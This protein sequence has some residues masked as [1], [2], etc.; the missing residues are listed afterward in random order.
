MLP[1]SSITSEGGATHAS[2][3]SAATP[4]VAAA[5][6]RPV[7][8]HH[9]C[10]WVAASSPVS[11]PGI[12]YMLPHLRRNRGSA[13]ELLRGAGTESTQRI[14]ADSSGSCRQASHPLPLLD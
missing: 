6:A 12:G 9:G 13:T 3:P 5:S 1:I 11:S 4:R 8:C 14:T 2:T 10:A 7:G